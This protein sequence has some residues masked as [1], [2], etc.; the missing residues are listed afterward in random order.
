M[1]P[2]CL[3]KYD[4]YEPAQI[5]LCCRVVRNVTSSITRNVFYLFKPM[6]ESR[7]L[8]YNFRS[9]LGPLDTHD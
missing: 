4:R 1:V 3:I 9:T 2:L 5:F 8:I 7:Q 6:M